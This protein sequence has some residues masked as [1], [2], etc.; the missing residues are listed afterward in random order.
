MAKGDRKAKQ[1]VGTFAEPAINS[2]P[3]PGAAEPQ[4][5]APSPVKKRAPRKPKA[6]TQSV[7]LPVASPVATAPARKQRKP[8][9]EEA[10]ERARANLVKARAAKAAGGMVE[11]Y[12]A[13]KHVQ[14]SKARAAVKVAEKK[15]K[16]ME[17]KE[18]KAARA[19]YKVRSAPMTLLKARR[20]VVKAMREEVKELREKSKELREQAQHLAMKA[21]NLPY[22]NDLV[23]Q[24]AEGYASAREAVEDTIEHIE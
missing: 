4:G 8:M 23:Q 22:D 16:R 21:R 1:V 14:V 7:T 13:S 11:R 5:A 3:L 18:H 17:R 19:D 10:K 12:T 2:P 15:Q 24:V 20:E 6:V 9:S